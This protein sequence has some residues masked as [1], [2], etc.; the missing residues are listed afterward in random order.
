MFA[1]FP[2]RAGILP[3]KGL[4][5][6]CL[7]PS[8]EEFVAKVLHACAYVASVTDF[9]YIYIYMCV[10]Y[11][12]MHVLVEVHVDIYIYIAF[13]FKNKPDCKIFI[14]ARPDF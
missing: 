1:I 13:F 7:A 10:L 4:M 8:S 14:P 6:Q 3:K 12:Y 2:H 9:Q 5:F 11:S